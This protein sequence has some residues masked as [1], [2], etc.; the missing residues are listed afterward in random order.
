MTPII[1]EFTCS[2]TGDEL[3]IILNAFNQEI[4]IL[5]SDYLEIMSNSEHGRRELEM[6]QGL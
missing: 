5:K 6:E 2:L 4:C 3:V 1:K